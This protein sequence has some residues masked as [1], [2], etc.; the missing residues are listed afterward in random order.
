V[1]VAPVI[2]GLTDHEIPA[3]VKAVAEAGACC[4]GMDDV[5]LPRAVATIFAEWLARHYPD[6]QA[7][8]LA[9]LK[10][11]TL[12]EQRHKLFGVACRRA[13][14]TGKMPELSAAAFRRPA[15]EQLRLL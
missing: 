8:V 5:R 9:Q 1:L 12:A 2:A 4:A 15:T 7:K 3:V 13:G 11:K 10:D 6:R 14:L